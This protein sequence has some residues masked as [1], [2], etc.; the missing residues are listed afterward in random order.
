MPCPVISYLLMPRKS[1][2]PAKYAPRNLC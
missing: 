2:Q 1:A